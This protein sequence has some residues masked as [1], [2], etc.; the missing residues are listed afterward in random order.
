M[1]RREA[2]EKVFQYIRDNKFTP[3][4]IQYGNCY[5][6]FDIGV[7]VVVHFNIKGLYGWRFGM[8]IE[9]DPEKLKQQD[10]EDCPAI[11]FSVNIN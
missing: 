6:I 7:D 9:T 5:C 1:T 4:N 11:H 3:T 8:W 2:A 10:S